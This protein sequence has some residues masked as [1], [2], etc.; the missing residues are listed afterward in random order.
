M[1][2]LRLKRPVCLWLETSGMAFDY[3]D[4]F[5]HDSKDRSL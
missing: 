2:K 1:T 5:L 4:L 3:S